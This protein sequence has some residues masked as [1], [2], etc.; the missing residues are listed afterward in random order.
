MADRTERWNWKKLFCVTLVVLVL[1]T[2]VFA[3][4]MLWGAD[5]IE[6]EER[7]SQEICLDFPGADAY[8]YDAATG[9]CVC[10]AG[11]R[12]IRVSSPV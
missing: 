5:I 3:G 1:Q 9:E 12:P 8:S 7:C 10:Y 4:L 2:L 11:D 6:S